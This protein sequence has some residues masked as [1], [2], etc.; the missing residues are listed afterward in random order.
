M[1]EQEAL[2]H[3][4]GVSAVKTTY[5]AGAS[6]SRHKDVFAKI[7]ILIDGSFSEKTD[8][9]FITMDKSGLVLKPNTVFH[10]NSF[11]KKGATILSIIFLN[12]KLSP[13][14][15]NHWDAFVHPHLSILGIQAWAKIKCIKS[16]S[17]L[18]CFLSRLNKQVQFFQNLSNTA[19]RKIREAEKLL[20]DLKGTTKKISDIAHDLSFHRVYFSRAFKTY[21]NVSPLEYAQHARLLKA[22]SLL[23]H[24]KSSLASIAYETGFSDQSHFNRHLK[25]AVGC[26]PLQLRALFKP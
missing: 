21:Y 6:M 18:N 2:Y 19:N 24:T 3:F 20:I 13:S 11:S 1:K 15:L 16:K 5:P 4:E 8:D 22:I 17:E 12:E 9:S 7:S 25:K 10:E 14:F 23:L 26:T